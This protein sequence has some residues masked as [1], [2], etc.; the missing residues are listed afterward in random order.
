MSW[1]A[2]HTRSE[3]YANQAQEF[4][5]QQEISLAVDLYC[6]AADAEL[7]ALEAI[8]QGK[9]R[10]IGITS[11][12]A[13][14]LYYK[15]KAFAK[16]KR[17]A[18][19]CLSQESLPPF[20]VEELEN[21]LQDIR[22]E[23]AR[24][25]S[26]IQFIE[27]QVLVSVSGGEV[28]YGA[29]PLDLILD[30]VEKIRSIF[31]RTTE[32]LLD[33]DLRKHGSP[34]Q[35]VRSYCD[36]WLLQAPPGSYQFAV[37][38]RKPTDQLTIPGIPDAGLRIEQITKKFLEIVRATT[39]DPSKELAAIVPNED[40]QK[41]FLKL[42]RELSPPLT[43]KSFEQMQIKSTD[44][45]E[46]NPVTLNVETRKVI[47]GVLDSK[48]LE[49]SS[50]QIT[51]HKNIQL[52]GILRGLQL[53]QDWIEVSIDGENKKIYDAK[54]EIDDVIGTM[55]NRRVVLDVVEKSNKQTEK[56]YYLRDIQ[57]EEDL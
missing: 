32:F 22:N 42:T 3:E 6:L 55:V 33:M 45:I 51:D 46:S 18:H 43:G 37:R 27:G 50:K 11:I 21:L 16:A 57:L 2:H 31:Y 20:A 4:Y 12:S 44:D 54:E 26:N 38:I 41:T 40:Y 24:T 53:D 13:V 5:R 48:Q 47:K 49:S 29:A 56:T 30:K 28:L 10:T 25:K 52:R 7:K 39:Q 36:P 1:L 19:K 35:M 17:V 8:D 9:I 15:A 14:S 23:E 34:N